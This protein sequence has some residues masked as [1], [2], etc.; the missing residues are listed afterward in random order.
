MFPLNPI[1]GSSSEPPSATQF[2]VSLPSNSNNNE[3]QVET[4][5]S[6][7]TS[8]GNGKLDEDELEDEANTNENLILLPPPSLTSLS[9]IDRDNHDLKF[10]DLYSPPGEICEKDP[11]PASEFMPLSASQ[12]QLEHLQPEP[13][14]QSI[15]QYMY[16][17]QYY[18]G[19]EFRR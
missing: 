7:S 1:C 14:K 2:M 15:Y 4:E 9:S 16:V 11:M 6:Q 12:P 5:T 13:G 3:I 19:N 18:T 10:E 17:Y 8:N